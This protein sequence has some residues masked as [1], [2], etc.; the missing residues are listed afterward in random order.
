MT[1]EEKLKEYARLAVVTGLAVKP[2]QEV[3]ISAS[4]EVADFV[5]LVMEQAYKA[6]ASDVVVEWMDSEAAKLRYQ[7]SYMEK[8][9]QCP[10]WTSLM[11]NTMAQRG[12][13]FLSIR[14][15]DP[16]VL[17]DVDPKKPAAVQ[18]A[19]RNACGPFVEAHR[20]GTMPWC[21]IGAASPKWAQAVFPDLPE[22]E[23]RDRLWDAIFQTA[24]VDSGDAVAAWEAHR[25]EFQKR[26]A[27]LNEQG[28]DALHYQN[29]LGT[30][31]TVGLLPGGIWCGGG[32]ATAD[33][34]WHFMN[35]PTEEV[36]TAPHRERTEG[37]VY[38][39]MPLNFNG[40]LIDQ[41]YLTFEKGRVVDFGAKQGEEVLRSILE[42]D[43]GAKYLGECALVPYDSPISNLEIL[44]YNTLYDEN[45]SCHLAVGSGISEAIEGG[46]SKSREELFQVG[47][48]DS[49]THVDFMF[50]TADLSITGIRPDGTRVP[51]FQNGNWAF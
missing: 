33:G 23:A 51:V 31:L 1:M 43:E 50:G 8:I 26:I 20:N 18:K 3:M 10:E 40:N 46:M 6:G 35:L 42:M 39:S 34:R 30:D 48:N 5:H 19:S 29:S 7:H 45:A 38:S 47:I 27:W 24:R 16:R 49:L 21:I 11:R 32:A 25:Q 2:G 41:F 13:A 22:Q 14:S 36:Y 17:A 44:F 9:S 28:F 4:V 15:D 12:A 37:T